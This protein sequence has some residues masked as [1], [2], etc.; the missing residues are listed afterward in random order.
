[1]DLA[2]TVHRKLREAQG[3]LNWLGRAPDNC[4]CK[5]DSI[6]PCEDQSRTGRYTF[7]VPG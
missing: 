3:E 5:Y 1:M 4:S 6:D 7:T 2:K